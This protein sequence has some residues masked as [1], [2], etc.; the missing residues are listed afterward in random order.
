MFKH[1]AASALLSAGALGLLSSECRSPQRLVT[2]SAE[3]DAPAPLLYRAARA[4][5]A[6]AT[7]LLR[8][9]AGEHRD[10]YWFGKLAELGDAES[11]YQLAVTTTELDKHR[12]LLKKAADLGHPSAQH[13]LALVTS[14]AAAKTLWLTASASQGYLPAQVSLYQWHLLNHNDQDALDWLTTAAQHDP[15]SQFILA[16]MMW[17]QG[18]HTD[19][20]ALFEQAAQGGYEQARA[21]VTHLKTHVPVKTLATRPSSAAQACAITL[22]PIA[23]SLESSI[24]AKDMMQAFGRDSRLSGLDICVNNILWLQDEV[25]FCSANWQRQ[26]RLGCDLT[27][28]AD[29]LKEQPFTHLVIFAAQGKANVNGGVMYL[30]LADTYKVFVH[31]LAHFAGFVD[32][33]PLSTPLAAVH[34][35]SKRAPNVV[36]AVKGAP[37]D[38]NLLEK[39]YGRG[40]PVAISRTRTCNNHHKQAYKPVA[41]MT[42]MEF[43]DEGLIPPL[44]LSLWEQQ[45]KDPDTLTPAYRDL[46]VAAFNSNNGDTGEYWQQRMRGF[47]PSRD[48]ASRDGG[49]DPP[50]TLPSLRR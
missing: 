36:T 42:F 48:T 38:L 30:D 26:R 45:L 35:E 50:P 19:A 27:P 24:Q 11:F 18:K 22:Q 28:L 34:C 49:E 5:H 14:S 12:A 46:A 15:Q 33:Y 23:T 20:K 29:M 13:E 3:V 47:Y 31:E 2:A 40:Y 4:G 6:E 32:E 25:L 17:K 39:W 21:F 16:K 9:W 10:A 41:D 8:D 37:I 7:E 44:Y 1:I 43:H